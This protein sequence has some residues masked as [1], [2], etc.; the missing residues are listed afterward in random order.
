MTPEGKVKNKLRKLFKDYD[1]LSVPFFNSMYGS[2]GFPDHINYTKKGIHFLVESK[3]LGKKL[4]P[5]QEI[6]KAKLLARKQH[7]FIYEGD[8]TELEQFL[9]NH[10]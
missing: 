1:V 3:A 7:H 2:K 4:S 5:Y 10:S 8:N 6:W 9:K